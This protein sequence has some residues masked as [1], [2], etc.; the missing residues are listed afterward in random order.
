[1][2]SL[3]T[4]KITKIGNSSGV[5]LPRE[6]MDKLNVIQG[7]QLSLTI[8]DGEIRLSPYDEN[9]KLQLDL[10]REIMREN[11]NMLRKLAE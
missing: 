2:A 6:I 4:L 8:T 3:D 1:M 9:K 11:R 5:I 7:D 10:A